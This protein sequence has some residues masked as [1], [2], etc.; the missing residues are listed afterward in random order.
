MLLKDI[1]TALQSREGVRNEGCHNLARVMF[2][3]ISRLL[4]FKLYVQEDKN[5]P[6]S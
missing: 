2:S 3:D 5:V 1:F 6:S 4:M